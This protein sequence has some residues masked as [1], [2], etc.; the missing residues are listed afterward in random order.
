[1]SAEYRPLEPIP[2]L[3]LNRLEKHGI[4]VE[5]GT[6]FA[7]LIGPHGFLCASPEGNSTHF[8]RSLCV[9]IQAVLDAIEKEYGV[10]IVDEDDPR[11][12]GFSTWGDMRRQREDMKQRNILVEGPW[13]RDGR[14]AVAWLSAAIELDQKWNGGWKHG[15]KITLF[16]FESFAMEFAERWLA[17]KGVF[18]ANLHEGGISETL[19]LMIEL[20]FF[21]LTENRYQMTLPGAITKAD[22]RRALF[23]LIEIQDERACLENLFVTLSESEAEGRMNRLSSMDLTERLADRDLLLRQSQSTIQC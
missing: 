6:R 14:F 19:L 20:G 23:R 10:T 4:A 16:T 7:K 8:E 15:L 5:M 22:V 9:D 17:G 1:M 13:N 11:F 2:F 12:W 21:T 18:S 3:S